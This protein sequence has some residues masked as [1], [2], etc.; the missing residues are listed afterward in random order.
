M[1][2]AQFF[3]HFQ[4]FIDDVD[5]DD[6]SSGRSRNLNHVDPDPS[7]SEHDHTISGLDLGSVLYCMIGCRNGICDDA[8]FFQWQILRK[9]LTVLSRGLRVFG[10]SAIDVIAQHEHVEADIL[11]AQ[12]AVFTVT[13]RKNRR[14]EDSVTHLEILYI[15]PGV[16]YD[17]RWLMTEDHR[18]FLERRNPVVDIMEICIADT[19]RGDLN[20]DFTRL[21]FRDVDLLD[22]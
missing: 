4:F 10:I 17:P 5:G 16:L 8:G 14:D 22:L 18:R 9:M 19:A 12:T 11:L 13:T 7:A 15:L 20:Q 2:C 3:R 6:R 21:D 1:F